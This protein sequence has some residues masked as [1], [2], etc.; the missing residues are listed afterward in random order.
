MMTCYDIVACAGAFISLVVL[1]TG[2]DIIYETAGDIIGKNVDLALVK[3]VKDSICTFPEVEGIYQIVIHNYGRDHLIGSAHIEVSDRFTVSWIDNLQRAITRKV[4]E[5]T[6]VEMLGLS[7][8]AINTRSKEAIEAREM[9]KKIVC[10]MEGTREMHGFYVNFLDRTISF[11]VIIEY[12]A[13]SK[14]FME[15]E[16]THKIL[17]IYPG[18]EVD[19]NVYH[20]FT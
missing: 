1:K 3:N 10:E 15:K 20:D 11:D 4:R 19:I 12:G 6:G 5:D 17:A 9:I 2:L 16:I 14:D 13:C 7:I 8:Y 18:Y